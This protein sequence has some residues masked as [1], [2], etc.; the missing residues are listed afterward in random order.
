MSETTVII[1]DDHPIVRQGLRTLLEADKS[2]RI[3]GEV[4]NGLAVADLVQQMRP[5]VLVLDLMMP[6]LSGVEV[7]RQVTKRSP[8]TSVIILSMYS[9]EAYVLETFKNGARGYV[10]KDSNLSDIILAVHEVMAGRLYLGSSF[11][12]RAIETYTKKVLDFQ[13]DPYE[14]L[15]ERERQVLHI[16]AEGRRDT[17][18]ARIL[19]VSP[20]T[21]ELHRTRLMKKL[22]LHSKSELV[23]YALQRGIIPPEEMGKIQ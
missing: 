5:D 7:L 21:A 22:G 15:T 1:A 9:S 10:I 4:G 13:L 23:R 2:I 11:T 20:R 17:E 6:G 8:K 12:Q 16:A 14:T 18:I 3:I 19:S